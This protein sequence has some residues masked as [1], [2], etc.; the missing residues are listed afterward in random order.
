MEAPMCGLCGK[1]AKGFAVIDGVR[2]CHD[3]QDPTCYEVSSIGTAPIKPHDG[4]SYSVEELIAV[5]E[6]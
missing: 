2:Y 1:P 3:D 6:R 5:L 4:V